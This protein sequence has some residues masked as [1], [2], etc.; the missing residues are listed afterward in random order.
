MIE[1]A[2]EIARGDQSADTLGVEAK[3]D[4]TLEV[5]LHNQLRIY[6]LDGFPIFFPQNQ[7]VVEKFGQEYGTASD[8]IVYNGPF[9]VKNWQQT[10]MNWDLAKNES[11]WDQ[12]AILAEE[13]HYD[14]VKESAPR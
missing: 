10:E 14:V 3:D 13:I 7:S 6:F 5:R 1:N 8:K 11:Y 4:Y 2:E 9:V 12:E